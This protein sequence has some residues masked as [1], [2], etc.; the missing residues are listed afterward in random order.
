MY[1]KY[2]TIVEKGKSESIMEVEHVFKG[3]V[4]P[5]KAIQQLVIEYLKD[6][7]YID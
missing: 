5:Q 2:K 6:N 4:S 1:K 3:T 7:K